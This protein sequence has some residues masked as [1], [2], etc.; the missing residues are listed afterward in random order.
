MFSIDSWGDVAAIATV[1]GLILAV[2][3]V[4][5]LEK[6]RQA[7][8]E[9]SLDKEYRKIIMEVPMGVLLGKTV[10]GDNPELRELL[11]N[12]L[13]LSNEQIYL[14]KIGRVGY[15]RWTGWRDGIEYNLSLPEFAE[16]WEEVKQEAPGTFTWLERLEEKDFGIDPIKWPCGCKDK[17]SKRWFAC[18][19]KRKPMNDRHTWMPEDNLLAIA[20][21][22]KTLESHR[23]ELRDPRNRTTKYLAEQ[24]GCSEE[25]AA[26]K[27]QN[28][29]HL[30][31]GGGLE[32]VSRIH[33]DLWRAVEPFLNGR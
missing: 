12:Y 7:Q 5:E 13:D 29:K 30:M 11:Y 19:R 1:A 6:V 26:S 25:S 28:Q 14:R 33:K 32:N 27:F 20:L 15:K 18:A 3:R 23:G 24:V 16:V 10:E 9:D 31:E 8:F 21:Y 22:C 4:R 2:W 17:P